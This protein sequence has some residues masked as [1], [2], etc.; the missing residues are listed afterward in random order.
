[1]RRLARG[2]RAPH[3]PALTTCCVCE[4]AAALGGPAVRER[5]AERAAA[6]RRRAVTAGETMAGW[7]WWRCTAAA[8]AQQALRV[9]PRQRP[10]SR[11]PCAARSP[12][13]EDNGGMGQHAH[14]SHAHSC[15]KAKSQRGGGGG[16]VG[17]DTAATSTGRLCLSTSATAGRPPQDTAKKPKL[18]TAPSTQ[19]QQQHPAPHLLR[20]R[21]APRRR[22]AWPA[23]PPPR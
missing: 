3:P 18:P 12:Q 1:M 4:L 5:G 9:S 10:P 15:A 17:S 22:A 16:R 21:R 13:H 7:R 20:G 19:R 23:C 6:V 8:Q 2:C 14:R 11:L